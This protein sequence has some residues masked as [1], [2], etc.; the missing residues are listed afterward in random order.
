MGSR[1]EME[2]AGNAGKEA[3]RERGWEGGVI[4]YLD[5]I[6]VLDSSVLGDKGHLL[7][8]SEYQLWKDRGLKVCMV[9][10]L[11]LL[12][13]TGLPAAKFFEQGLLPG[14]G[15]DAMVTPSGMWRVM[16]Y[17]AFAQRLLDVRTGVHRPEGPWGSS[18]MLLEMATRGGAWALFM[19][20]RTG[21]LE[22]G[23]DADWIMIDTSRPYLHPNVDN[24]RLVSNMVWSGEGDMVDSV[25]VAGKFL[26]RNRR[27]LVWDEE[28]VIRTGERTLAQI[29]AETG[30]DQ[31]LPPR[32]PGQQVRGWTYA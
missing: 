6:G 1:F 22:V 21:S 4:E 8:P 24:R 27:C 18:E 20:Q 19:D 9:P 25:M 28:E 7:E 14:M 32:V 30:D 31:R 23:K 13:G 10:T 12:D 17:T 5:H 29:N 15:T 3:V 26:M 16:R 11:R 2:L